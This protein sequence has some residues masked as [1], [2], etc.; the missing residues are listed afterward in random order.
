MTT[1]AHS[2]AGIVL[3]GYAGL[4]TGFDELVTPDGG[5]RSHWHTFARGLDDI[6][7]EEFTNRWR[8]A[9]QLIRENG[10]TYNVYGD[11][12]APIGP[13]SLIRFRSS[14]PRKKANVCKSASSSAPSCSKRFS[15]MC[16]GRRIS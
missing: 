8:E 16:M 6:G 3:N 4:P 13:G 12:A 2:A 11:P 1:T 9:Q 10:V 15:A 5:V 14:S 7:L